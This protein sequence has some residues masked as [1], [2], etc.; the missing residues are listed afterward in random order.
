MEIAY[1]KNKSSKVFVTTSIIIL[2]SISLPILIIIS[3]STKPSKRRGYN[4]DAFQI[5][6]EN[7][8]AV[9]HP[10]IPLIL[11]ALRKFQR[12]ATLPAILLVPDW[13]G[14]TWSPLLNELSVKR[15]LFGSSSNILIPGPGMR[16]KSFY[17]PPGHYVA[18]LIKN[19]FR[20]VPRSSSSYPSNNNPSQPSHSFSNT[21]SNSTSPHIR[22]FQNI[23]T[24]FVPFFSPDQT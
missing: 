2:I 14:Q 22:F 20:T 3:C 16:K 18:H 1:L 12:E 8:P 10:P 7:I 21:P 17:L 13:I 9:I 5:S 4:G 19:K 11:R 24:T 23:P 15:I 6:W